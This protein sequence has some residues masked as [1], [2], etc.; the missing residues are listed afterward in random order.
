MPPNLPIQPI[1]NVRHLVKRGISFLIRVV[2]FLVFVWLSRAFWGF[3]EVDGCFDD[4]GA[5]D[6]AAGICIE[7]RHGQWALISSRPFAGWV[8][9]LGIPALFVWGVLVVATK[10]ISRLKKKE[11]A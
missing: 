5:I 10:V 11:N 8:F 6:H 2:A 7:S 9:S 1:A 3:L 4:G